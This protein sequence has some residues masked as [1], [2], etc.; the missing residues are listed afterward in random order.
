M[1]QKKKVW[2]KIIS[3]RR[4]FDTSPFSEIDADETEPCSFDDG[5]ESSEMSMEGRLLRGEHRVELVWEESALSGMEGSSASLGFDLASPGLVTM[6]R[7]GAV[8][9]ALV[10]EKGKR[11]ICCYRTPYSSFEVCTYTVSVE[12]RMLTEGKLYLDY[13]V[14]FHGAQAERC[15]MEIR[16]QE[17][18]NLF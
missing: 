6:L 16:V 8:S 2:I 10:F 1:T 5:E 11:H 18:Q 12:N 15:R 9:T 17:Q 3:H 7:E 4:E 14:E 13:I